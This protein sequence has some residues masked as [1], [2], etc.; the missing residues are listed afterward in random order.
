MGGVAGAAREDFRGLSLDV[1][2]GREWEKESSPAATNHLETDCTPQLHSA[3][4][5]ALTPALC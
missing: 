3:P 1:R 4:T 5:S 2:P